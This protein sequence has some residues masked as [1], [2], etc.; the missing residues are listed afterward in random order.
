MSDTGSLTT[1]RACLHARTMDLIRRKVDFQN[2]YKGTRSNAIHTNRMKAVLIYIWISPSSGGGNIKVLSLRN[3][4]QDV[5]LRK[6]CVHLPSRL[7]QQD[8][9]Q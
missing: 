8:L 7:G 2:C 6:S 1:Y 4:D 3:E 5:D 9:E